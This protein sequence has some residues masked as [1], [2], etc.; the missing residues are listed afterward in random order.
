MSEIV[1]GG[2]GGKGGGENVGGKGKGGMVGLLLKSRLEGGE[3]VI[4]L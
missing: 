3:Q 1:G 4:S 2:V